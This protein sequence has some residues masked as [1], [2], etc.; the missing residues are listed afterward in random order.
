MAYFY[1]GEVSKIQTTISQKPDNF[2]PK[3]GNWPQITITF[4]NMNFPWT[5]ITVEKY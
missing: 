1:I 3:D 2:Q 4:A 5:P